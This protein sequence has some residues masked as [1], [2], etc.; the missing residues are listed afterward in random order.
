M[1]PAADTQ[2]RLLLSD[3]DGKV[4]IAARC[5]KT[6]RASAV[7]CYVDSFC[8]VVCEKTRIGSLWSP[9]QKRPEKNPIE[10]L[11]DWERKTNTKNVCQ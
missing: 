7:P 2:H 6:I 5:V 1:P 10:E 4:G 9:G 8:H 11:I 3:I